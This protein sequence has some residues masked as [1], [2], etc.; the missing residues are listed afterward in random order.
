M[1]NSSFL[2]PLP[3][4]NKQFFVGA[5]RVVS[6]L[7]TIQVKQ[8]VSFIAANKVY[9]KTDKTTI[10]WIDTE[11]FFFLPGVD[12]SHDY[13]GAWATRLSQTFHMVLTVSVDSCAERKS[14]P[15]VV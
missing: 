2:Q 4:A 7:Q 10:I 6:L 1:S 3:S 8:G 14:A 9:T 15:S 12:V 5:Q 11:L 13:V